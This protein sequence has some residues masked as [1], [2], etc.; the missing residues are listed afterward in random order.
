M[1]CSR[2]IKILLISI[3][4][5]F[6]HVLDPIA[7][8]LGLKLFHGS[9]KSFQVS[10]WLIEPYQSG[11]WRGKT[12]QG[13][14]Y[15]VDSTERQMDKL[16]SQKRKYC[17]MEWEWGTVK[18]SSP[19]SLLGSAGVSAGFGEQTLPRPE[20]EWQTFLSRPEGGV[21]CG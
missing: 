17:L 21:H 12:V 20:H 1:F 15:R 9:L 8:F 7:L 18:I 3:A 4:K 19:L 5:L 11:V 13:G 6:L 2:L 10:R 14:Q 16:L